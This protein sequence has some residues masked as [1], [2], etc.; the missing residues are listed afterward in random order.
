MIV[1][2]CS[3]DN[4]ATWQ[5]LYQSIPDILNFQMYGIPLTGADICGF[6]GNLICV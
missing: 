4:H 1:T 6:N 3:G 5:D 2:W